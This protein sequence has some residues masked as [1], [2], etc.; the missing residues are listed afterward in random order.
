MMDLKD[1]P[2]SKRLPIHFVREGEVFPDGEG[3]MCLS[4]NL[5]NPTAYVR[6]RI[7][8]CYGKEKQIAIHVEYGKVTDAALLHVDE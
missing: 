3:V 5:E 4:A 8:D 6:V 7:F 1:Y 2:N